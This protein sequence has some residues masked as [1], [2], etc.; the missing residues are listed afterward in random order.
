MP[1][2]SG[3]SS[4]VT[5]AEFDAAM[6]RARVEIDTITDYLH[7]NELVDEDT[8]A[9]VR[10]WAEYI[11]ALAESR[12]APRRRSIEEIRAE[13]RARQIARGPEPEL[14]FPGQPPSI[15]VDKQS[16]RVRLVFVVS[17]DQFWALEEAGRTRARQRGVEVVG[18]GRIFGQPWSDELCARWAIQHALSATY[19]DIHEVPMIGEVVA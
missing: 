2:R 12:E 1:D 4:L 16:D 8:V 15:E 17:L 10:E 9:G 3:E 5:E 18:P 7:G 13:A 11:V 14:R 6:E 19:P